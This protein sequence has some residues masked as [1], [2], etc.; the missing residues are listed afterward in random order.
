[1]LDSITALTIAN[2]VILVS[3]GMLGLFLHFWGKLF[4]LRNTGHS[5]TLKSYFVDYYPETVTSFGLVLI[6][7][8]SLVESGQASWWMAAIIGYNADSLANKFRNRAQKIP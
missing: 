8:G 2:I 1:M 4:E 3:G 5:I 7:I 6:A